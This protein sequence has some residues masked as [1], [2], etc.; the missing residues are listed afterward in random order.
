MIIALSF[1]AVLAIA[2]FDVASKETI[3]SFQLQ[4]FELG[5]ISDRTITS[6]KNIGP[7][8]EHPIT[9]EKNEKIIKKGF[10]ITEE[11]YEKLQKL[12]ASPTYIDY[13]AFANA[14]IFYLLLAAL[15]IFLF[16]SKLCG[17]KMDTKE[18]VFLAI[19]FV[20]VQLITVIASK[21]AFFDTSFA[22]PI[23]IPASL[24]V[25]L[26]TVLFGQQ[27]AIFFVFLL[28]FSVLFITNFDPIPA[29]FLVASSI[30]AIRI[31][32]RIEKRIDMI[33]AS[34]LLG[35]FNAIFLL[36]IKIIFNNPQ[37]FSLSIIFGNVFNGF[38]SGILALG[39]LTPL[40]SLLNT[41]SVFRLMDLSDL[42]NPV[43]KKMLI[44]AP[45]TYNHSMMVASLAESAC[46]EIGANALLARVGAYYHDLGKIEQP[47]YFVENQMGNNKHEEL[48]PRLSVSVIR[49]HVKKGLE[50][51]T[52]LRLPKEVLAIIE[53]HHGNSLISYFYAEA[54]KQ[55]PQVSA[56]E[57]S[58]IGTPPQSKESAVVMLADTVEAACRTLD[59]P[60]VSRL[61]KFIKQLVMTKV[62]L[63][64]LD[65]SGLTFKELSSIQR[66]FV[67]ILAGYYH[68][69]IEYPNQKDPDEEETGEVKN[70]KGTKDSD[71]KNIKHKT[72]NA[73]SVLIKKSK[74]DVKEK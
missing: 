20:L 43:M 51:A 29:F 13:R 2:F 58:Y 73:N 14:L 50:K 59:K 71:K 24:S 60:S 57:F 7:T 8:I 33:F 56:E 32:R 19:L 18:Q 30:T 55:D 68:S 63:G 69:R 62:E 9:V 74:K 64:Q 40:E 42:N 44:V 1:L 10:P 45:G 21:M 47:E 48:N 54:K 26:L 41:A 67:T 70:E 4:E 11:G 52:Q 27:N 15:A 6:S 17:K 35:I 46:H 16:S 34:V 72:Q 53:E 61:E 39:L 5:Q 22:L 12:A 25:M 49:R 28:A 66:A 3:V 31:V 37:T 38:V 65:N 36:C 23:L